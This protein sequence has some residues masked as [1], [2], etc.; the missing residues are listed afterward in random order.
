MGSQKMMRAFVMRRIGEVAMMDKPVPRP[1]PN[2][3]LIRTTAALICTSD[4]HTV[5]GG[6]G[7]RDNLT[8]GHEAVGVIEELGSAVEGFTIG[9]RVVVNAVTP[10]WYC[11][12]CQ[13]GYPS[14]CGGMLGGWRSA[15]TRDGSMAEYFIV[16]DARGNLAPIPDDLSD[17][18]A[19]YCCDM[20]STGFA[21]AENAAIPIGGT[22]AIFA[23]GPVGLMAT[24]GEIG[25][26]H[27]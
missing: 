6:I 26:A 8:L 3:A 13:R 20:L 17:E 25:R 24:V 21:G 10:D 5:G 16:N 27:V 11:P 2:E 7:P 18:Q 9:R 15:N 4:T 1:G 22:V 23:Q 19:A 14:Q 12:N